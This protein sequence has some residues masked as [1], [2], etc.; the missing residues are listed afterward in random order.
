MKFSVRHGAPIPLFRSSN[1][2]IDYLNACPSRLGLDS[3][4]AS[5]HKLRFSR[6]ITDPSHDYSRAASIMLSLIV[7]DWLSPWRRYSHLWA[8]PM[9]SAA[10]RSM[11]KAKDYRL[12]ASEVLTIRLGLKL[13]K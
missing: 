5:N 10:M 4:R 1:L 11:P 7:L 12:N 13:F 3:G 6:S 8:K 2:L 9:A